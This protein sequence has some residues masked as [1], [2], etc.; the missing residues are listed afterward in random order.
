LFNSFE[1]AHQRVYASLRGQEAQTQP[2][3]AQTTG[4]SLPTIINAVKRL[5]A[6]GL[7]NSSGEK[8]GNGRPSKRYRAAPERHQIL[9]IDLGGT[10][11]RAGVFDLHGVQQIE[12]ES[13]GLLEFSRMPRSKSLDYL[14][15][16]AAQF[17]KVKR[18]GLCAPGIVTP[19]RHLERSWLFELRTI[20]HTE[21]ERALRKP[22]L[23]ENDARSGAWGE[24]RRGRGSD[25]SAFVIFAFG[26]GAGLVSG[27]RLLRG[28]RGAAGEL[29]YLPP[30]TEDIG[31]KPRVG[32]LA[33]EF[34]ERLQHAS[35]TPEA[36]DWKA[37]V[38]QSAAE[39]DED[40]KNAVHSAVQHLGLALSSVLTVL[41]PKSIILREEFP[42]TREL[43]LEP[44]RDMLESIG[45]TAPLEVSALGRDA[46]LIGVALLAAEALEQELLEIAIT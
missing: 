3:L 9:A 1:L 45:L 33:Y 27:G 13:I 39:G 23:L 38:F 34:F 20:T 2:Q 30:R 41:D 16:L 29:S 5:E 46:G 8:R 6:K 28:A 36:F 10:R 42:H 19:E 40:A 15:D 14:R 37:Q 11:V 24:Y 21:L 25:D 31:V 26:I 12:I 7:I 32:A 44:L 35:H 43:V 18:I 17:P 22:V 4:L